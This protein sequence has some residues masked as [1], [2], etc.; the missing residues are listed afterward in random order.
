MRPMKVYA[1]STDYESRRDISIHLCRFALSIDS[2]AVTASTCSMMFISFD[3]YPKISKPLQVHIQND[4]FEIN[5]N[6]LCHL[7]DFKCI[8]LAIFY[9]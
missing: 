3:R 2:L 4:N 9:N 1:L 7:V 5:K 8:F 6:N